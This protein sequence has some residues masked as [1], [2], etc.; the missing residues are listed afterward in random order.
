M[1]KISK[2]LT[3][4]SVVYTVNYILIHQ[5]RLSWSNGPCNADKTNLLF[6]LYFINLYH[7]TTYVDA[8][9]CYRWSSLVC[10]SVCLSVTIVSFAKTAEPIKMLFG[11]WTL[12]GRRNY[13]LDEGPDPPCRGGRGGTL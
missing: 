2:M 3:T 12:V 7:S 8:A 10:R 1:D 5:V 6:W 9:Y 4:I 13:V 11:L